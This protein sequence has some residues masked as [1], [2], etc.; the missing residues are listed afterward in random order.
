M[1][2]K[3]PKLNVCPKQCNSVHSASDLG[4]FSWAE[5]G[6]KWTLTTR[7]QKLTQLQM[8][9]Q[10]L[11][12]SSILPLLLHALPQ[13]M[14]PEDYEGSPGNPVITLFVPKMERISKTVEGESL[15][16]TFLFAGGHLFYCSPSTA[17]KTHGY[18]HRLRIPETSVALFIGLLDHCCL[19]RETYVYAQFQ[20]P[21][22]HGLSFV[23]LMSLDLWPP[24]SSSRNNTPHKLHSPPIQPGTEFLVGTPPTV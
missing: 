20:R 5:L 12:V 22:P 8:D 13:T 2:P 11:H 9:V 15:S 14:K 1:Y 6:I 23:C 18:Y 16:F 21:C 10:W 17:I 24:N 19:N 3:P 7:L 4:L